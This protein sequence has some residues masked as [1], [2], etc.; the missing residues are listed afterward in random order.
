MAIIFEANQDTHNQAEKGAA[1]LAQIQLWP[2][3]EE[4]GKVAYKEYGMTADQ[5]AHILPEYQRFLTLIVLDSY[6]GLGMFSQQIDN[7]WHS[8]IL[9]THRYQDFC[10]RYFQGHMIHHLPCLEPKARGQCTV[11]NSCTGCNTKC[12]NCQG[13]LLPPISDI[14]YRETTYPGAPGS[15]E[16][17]SQVYMQVFQCE[18]PAV[19]TLPLEEVEGFSPARS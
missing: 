15:V 12:K 3:W 19:W 11:C 16:H 13:N 17:F 14:Q 1:L 8:H 5:Y 9:S 10:E 7:I 2:Y 6:P 18:P 4:I